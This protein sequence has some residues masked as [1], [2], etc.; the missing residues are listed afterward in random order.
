MTLALA[1][2]SRAYGWRWQVLPPAT[3]VGIM[4]LLLGAVLAAPRE[5]VEGEVQRLLYIHVPA[6]LA[7]YLAFSV[8]FVASI[9]LLWTRDM[10]YDPVARSAASVGVLFI[11]LNLATGAIWGKP[12]WGVYWTWDARL[13]STLVLLLIFIAYL[14]ARS[15]SSR[16]DEQAARY[17][18]VF[19]IIGFLDVPLVHFAVEWW[20]TLHPQ[21][22]LPGR[23]LPGEMALVLLVGTVAVSLLAVWLIVLRTETEAMA[24]RADALGAELDRFEGA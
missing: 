3:G 14:L 9:L 7:A 4:A 13:T 22:I 19:A 21:P 5:A 10:R 12:I 23:D 20:R 11:A 16:A 17:M 6:V 24:A 18:A 8:T 2:A 15:L 1:A